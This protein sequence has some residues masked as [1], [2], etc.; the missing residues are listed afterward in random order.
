MTSLDDF[1]SLCGE[2]RNLRARELVIGYALSEEEEQV[3]SN[4]MNLLLSFEDEVTED[5]QLIDNSLT[6]LEKAAAGKLLSYL[7]RTQMRDLSHL[8]KVVH[9]EIKDYLQ[10]DYATKSSLDLL[11][12]G[13]TGKK[14]GSLY[15]LLDETKTAMGMRLLRTWIDRPLIDLKR[16][17]NRQA[18][19][20]V[21]WITS[22]N[23]VTWSR[24]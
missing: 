17:E 19:V 8:Q 5:V 21:F 1:T 23:G 11:E 3:F 13:R 18:V 10:M 12:N 2:I 20:Q 7:H 24:L 15:W 4:Q 9:Y 14:H 16:I 6:D 22:L